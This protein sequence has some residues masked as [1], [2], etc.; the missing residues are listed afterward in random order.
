MGL[1][2]LHNIPQS[3]SPY[4]VVPHKKKLS[5]HRGN[6]QRLITNESSTVTKL[7]ALHAAGKTFRKKLTM[8]RN[9]LNVC[10][11]NLSS[12]F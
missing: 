10:H 7:I 1:E 3:T 9:F 11:E 6:Q 5:T 8:V 12:V 2:H 4:C